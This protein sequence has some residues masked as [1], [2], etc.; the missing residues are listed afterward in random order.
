MGDINQGQVGDCYLMAPLASFAFSSPSRLMNTAVDLGDGTYMVS[1]PVAGTGGANYVR[2]DGD[3]SLAFQ[4]PGASG[5]IWGCI[6]EKAYAF[7]RTTQNSYASLDTGFT[8]QTMQQMGLSVS[9]I[10]TTQ[11]A[12]TVASLVAARLAAGKALAVD[13]PVTIVGGAPLIASHSYSVI[14]VT[15]DA[16]GNV[17]YT[18][19]NPWGFDGAGSDANPN[20]GIITISSAQLS[21]NSPIIYSA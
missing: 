2:V 12:G 3:L 19:R 11:A 20:D 18:L 9:V 16:S 10:D 8:A 17:W 7:F 1:F 14:G 4:H 15:T 13:T 6:I 5:D 21:A